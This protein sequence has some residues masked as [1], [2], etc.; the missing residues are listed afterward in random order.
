MA[1]PAVGNRPPFALA[2]VSLPI[3]HSDESV[4]PAGQWCAALTARLS[5]LVLQIEK[6]LWSMTDAHSGLTTPIAS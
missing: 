2:P 6:G 5:Q 3:R 4:A 1:G